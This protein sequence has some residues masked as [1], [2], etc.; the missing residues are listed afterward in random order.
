M[1]QACVL[2]QVFRPNHPTPSTQSIYGKYNNIFTTCTNMN[3]F[4]ILKKAVTDVRNRQ[5]DRLYKG[6]HQTL[7]KQSVR[8]QICPGEICCTAKSESAIT[9]L[10]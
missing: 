4:D 3:Q 2:T 8:H 6:E 9:M 1:V 7:T 5:S 10:M